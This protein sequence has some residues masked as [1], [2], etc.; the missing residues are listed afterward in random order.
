MIGLSVVALGLIIVAAL[1]LNVM[2]LLALRRKD[3]K[4]A[5]GTVKYFVLSNLAFA[6]ITQ[7]TLGYCVQLVD[8]LVYEHSR[9]FCIV[10]GFVI[11][12]CGLV[13]IVFMA[14]LSFD[15]C[16]HICCPLKSITY[17]HRMPFAF[18]AVGWVYG[19]L[20]SVLPFIQM[21]GYV[22]ETKWSCSL[23]WVQYNLK[24]KLFLYSL[25]FFCYALPVTI[26]V[27]CFGCI[28]VNIKRKANGDHAAN[29][30][31]RNTTR[32]FRAARTGNLRLCLFISTTFVLAWTPYCI[33]A[34]YTVISGYYAVPQELLLLSEVAAKCSSWLNPSVFFYF[35][36]T[37]RRFL[38]QLFRKCF[39]KCVFSRTR[40]CG[41]TAMNPFIQADSRLQGVR[42]NY[43]VGSL[44]LISR[45]RK[46][47]KSNEN[48][49]I[50]TMVENVL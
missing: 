22:H 7:V 4:K 25:F 38:F 37:S 21:G 14:I 19:F 40:D 3:M 29:S 48:Y 35:D 27:T 8:S 30:C 28:H 10:S 18:V 34:G 24:G 11:T 46:D 32:I 23:K 41:A 39:A 12:F 2:M 50:I 31:T 15:I 17:E 20:W 9:D 42:P 33:A 36:R 16:V 13:S 45:G 5:R 49:N 44:E 6:D 43:A 26:I 47:P 1:L